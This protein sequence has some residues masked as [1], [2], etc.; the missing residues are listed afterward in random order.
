M[1]R[2]LFSISIFALLSL[3]L[4]ASP[5]DTEDPMSLPR[6]ET[7]DCRFEIPS[8]EKIECGYLVVPEKRTRPEG[9]TIRISVTVVKSHSAIPAPD[10]IIYING[11]PGGRSKEII[12]TLHQY[13]AWLAK[14]DLILFD[15]RGAG[16][17]QPVLN[18]PE[19][20]E[21]WIQEAT[22]ANLTTEAL[23]APRLACRDRWLNQGID[24]TAYNSSETAADV[25]D[26]WRALDYDQVNLYSVS[27]G[28]LVAQL[29]M[30][31]HNA[32]DDI[33]S[34]ILDSPLP[35]AVPVSA[36]T[37]ARLSQSMAQLFE[38]CEAALLC[39]AAYPNLGGVYPEVIHRL[40]TS[41]VTLSAANPLNGESFSF[42]FDATDFGGLIMYGHYRTF[43]ALIYDVHDGDYTAAIDTQQTLIRNINRGGGDGFGLRTSIRCNEPWFTASP[44]QRAAASVYPETVFMDDPLDAAL[45]ER[46]PSFTPTDQT[47]VVSDIPT[48]ILG[49]EYDTRLPFAYGE[50]IAASLTN[51]YH[52]LVPAAPHS[53]VEYGGACPRLIMLSFVDNPTHPPED[54][55]LVSAGISRFDTQFVIRAAA[56]RFP[57]QAALG[58]M[59]TLVVGLAIT[60]GIRAY[61]RQEPG[62]RFSFAWRNSWRLV[63]WQ[64]LA[65]SAGL[66]GFA[67]YASQADLLPIDPAD[68]I[69]VALPI[70]VAIQA[71]F[72]FSPEDEPAL[73]VILA[74]P[75]PPTW[76]LLERLATLFI[77]QGSV[78]TITSLFLAQ[79]TGE[80]L[81]I[82]IIRWLP[83]TFFLSGVAV[84]A[85]LATRRAL[86]GVL[87]VCLLWVV[88]ALFGD[89]LVA[90]WPIAW[91]FH[92]YLQPRQA[93]YPLNRLFIA[94]LGISLIAI[95]AARLVADPE[96]LLPGNR[97]SKP[98]AKT[99]ARVR[100]RDAAPSQVSTIELTPSRT[101]SLH[102][103]FAQLAAMIRYEFLLSWRRAAL[104]VLVVGLM[105]TPLLGAFIARDDFRGY[106]RALAAGTLSLEVAKAEIT[107]QLV[108]VS[109]L[110]TSLIAVIMVPLVVADTIPKDRQLGVRELLDTLPLS[111]GA[112][113]AGKLLSLWF[114]LLIGL[115]LAAL[116]AGVVWWLMIGP[117][118]VAK[119]LDLWF[120]GMLGLTFINAGTSMLLAAGQPNRRRATLVG[121]AY[122]M[123][124]LAGLG[125]AFLSRAGW[126]R[127]LNPAR[128][129]VMLYYLLAISGTIEG[130][131]DL[132]R[133]ALEFVQQIASRGEMLRS[134]TAGL[135]QLG[136]VWL[137]VWQWLKGREV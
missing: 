14:R 91:P 129:S 121:S 30:R 86:F 40:T 119:Y 37:P 27:Y 137:V 16:W 4:S 99:S 125:L 100:V 59:A 35:L 122:A 1:S 88:L 22:G 71:A 116:V 98:G 15:Q 13:D 63:G 117:F 132:T 29:V 34:V 11:G 66:L 84:Y 136:L 45:C 3:T 20:K 81:A 2:F 127:W 94:L 113:L 36:E 54:D 111:P 9:R 96:R 53:V 17:S 39:R 23:L 95:A 79:S 52:H 105:T 62:L 82:T 83:L 24:L 109:W 78:G 114:G 124:C 56:V 70:I 135:V 69:A 26:L 77:L 106:R 97:R 134:L 6:F 101:C 133:A 55:C 8:G 110:G 75:R 89:F 50:M 115:S 90:R 31:D 58:L 38:K 102:S 93:D 10:P 130:N 41:P 76:I 92:L 57:V 65:T 60:A 123:L 112:Y 28:T 108:L 21:T 12:D 128:P 104:P 5:A 85:T 42:Q 72:L 18:C 25:A 46:W 32:R 107:G 61:Q 80:S 87:V 43:P 120:V 64:S 126:W 67:F 74:T 19:M 73:E 48:L 68:A 47:P 7:T 131:D 33:R 51:S 44:E 49:G 103:L 118:E